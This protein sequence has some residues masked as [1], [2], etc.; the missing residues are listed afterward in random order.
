MV[1]FCLS[2]SIRRSFRRRISVR[3]EDPCI[4]GLCQFLDSVVVQMQ[5]T[6]NYIKEENNNWT[7]ASSCSVQSTLHW[8]ESTTERK[9][10]ERKK[11]WGKCSCV[12]HMHLAGTHFPN[13]FWVRSHYFTLHFFIHENCSLLKRD[14]FL[15][16][17]SAVDVYVQLEEMQLVI[18]CH[19]RLL[20]VPNAHT[21]WTLPIYIEHV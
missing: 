17:F 10:E 15:F 2:H 8:M 5:L 9:N 3:A 21:Y 12:Q 11:E 16:L 20:T 13:S 18:H 7:R 1:P 14:R 19:V 4:E 6:K